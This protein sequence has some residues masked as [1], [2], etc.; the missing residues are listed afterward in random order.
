[1]TTIVPRVWALAILLAWSIEVAAQAP[2]A[3]GTA[4]S[5]VAVFPRELVDFKPYSSNPVFQAAGAGQWDVRIRERGWILKEGDEYR[6]WYTGYDGTR[7]GQKML[8]LAT[9]RDGIHWERH[10]QNPIY[11]DHWVEDMMVLKHEGVYYMFA[12]GAQDQA[13][14]LTSP[15][16]VRWRR[17]GPLDVRLNNG[18]PI[19]PGPYGTPFAMVKDGVWHL[20]YERRD[21]G[22]WLATSKDR[23]VWTNVQDEPV[24]KPGPQGYDKLMIALNQVIQ[25]NGRY[26]ALL[27]GTGSETLPRLWA[28]GVAVS[29]DLIHW[30][31]YPGNPL[32]PVEQDKSSGVWV[33][34]GDRFRL[35]TM[36]NEVHLHLPGK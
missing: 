6:L 22:I 14:L 16:G 23:K 32:F 18:D 7:E 30:T 29:D 33:P 34:D 28:T 27:H 24:L 15:D 21:A 31:K 1:M 35:Y 8:G 11:R 13:H 25:R 36:H 20:F 3:A 2:S 19:P 9:S 17:E 10:P 4:A 26:Y 12:E 5:D